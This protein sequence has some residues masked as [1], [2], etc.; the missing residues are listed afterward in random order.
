MSSHQAHCT[1]PSLPFHL[2]I[3]AKAPR[4]HGLIHQWDTAQKEPLSIMEWV[5]THNQPTKVIVRPQEIIAHLVNKARAHLLSLAGCDF[6][7]IYLPL[8]TTGDLKNLLQINESLQF[9]LHSYPGQISIDPPSH[10]QF[11][12]ELIWSLNSYKAKRLSKLGPFFLMA[13]GLPTSQ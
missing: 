8:A 1:E 2:I 7:C 5:F 4:F 11:K 13:Q 3:L 9:T 6:T 12:L 10:K